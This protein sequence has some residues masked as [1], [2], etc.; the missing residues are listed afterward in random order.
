MLIRIVKVLAC[1]LLIFLVLLE[2]G[3]FAFLSY[4]S[5][6]VGYMSRLPTYLDLGK[7]DQYAPYQDPLSPHV[8][9]TA[10][11]WATWHPRNRVFRHRM[12]CFD[13]FMHFNAEGSRGPLPHPSDTSTVIFLGD[14]FTE[15]YGL[16]ED[17]TLSAL[18]AQATGQPV[19]N[20]GSSGYIGTTQYSLIY[21]AFARKYRHGRV[22]VALH[23]ANDFM[24]NDIQQYDE[25]FAAM[26]RYRPY[27][28]DPDHLA[29]IVYKGSLDSSSFRWDSFQALQ[30]Q[31]RGP[32]VKMGVQ[33]FW[34]QTRYSLMYKLS[35]LTYTRRLWHAFRKG[36]SLPQELS[37]TSN[38]LRILDFDIQQILQIATRKGAQVTFVNLPSQGLLQQANR[39]PSVDSQ[40]LALEDHLA[41]QVG[42]GPHSFH[43]FYRFLRAAKVDPASLTFSCDAHYNGAAMQQL[44]SFLIQAR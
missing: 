42:G 8:I 28:G 37:Y 5:L 13:V 23:L 33:T 35:H 6:D 17:S 11:S 15:G 12:R 2:A 20:L 19:L 29:R 39:H 7:G 14:S 1:N 43:S 24:E 22:F 3:S 40:Y 21:E 26:R 10:V 36:R 18:Y 41:E 27:R 4:N 34:R 32:L 38:D 16:P 44:A 25:Q 30:H 31:R 9:D